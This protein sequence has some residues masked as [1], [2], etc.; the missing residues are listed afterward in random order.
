MRCKISE[1]EGRHEETEAGMRDAAAE[2]QRRAESGRV[3]KVK[4]IRAE[5]NK[6]NNRKKQD[7]SGFSA[8]R[9]LQL[10]SSI[11]K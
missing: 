2:M 5:K 1:G 9:G 6:Y 7:R 8:P 10:P 11:Y 3:K 4:V